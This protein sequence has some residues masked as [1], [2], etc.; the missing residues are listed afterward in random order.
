M[1]DSRPL[2]IIDDAYIGHSSQGKE[3]TTVQSIEDATG[4]LSN[5]VR[6]MD[7]ESKIVAPSNDFTV[8]SYLS[9]LSVSNKNKDGNEDEAGS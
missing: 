1:N 6:Q 7:E 5:L 2:N 4:R 3:T 8:Q 9:H